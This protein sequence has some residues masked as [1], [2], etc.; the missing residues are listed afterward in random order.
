MNRYDSSTA[1]SI[2]FP[3]TS[4]AILSAR[5]SLQPTFIRAGSHE[6]AAPA[7]IPD[8]CEVLLVCDQP[9]RRRPIDAS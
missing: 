8:D 5:R 2:H 7:A 3:S 1:E 4:P 9:P 6:A